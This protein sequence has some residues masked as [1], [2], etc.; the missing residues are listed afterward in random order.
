MEPGKMLLLS[1]TVYF[2]SKKLAKSHLPDD[3]LK[4]LQLV[5]LQV[6]QVKA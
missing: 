6:Q 4:D 5:E 2:V 1:L 3:C